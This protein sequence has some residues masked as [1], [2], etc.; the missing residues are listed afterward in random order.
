[1]YT[2]EIGGHV[3]TGRRRRIYIIP[4]SI[5]EVA[6]DLQIAEVACGC[7]LPAKIACPETSRAEAMGL[8]S[9]YTTSTR[10]V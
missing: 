10:S 1:M 7:K 3:W 9:E 4:A 8:G 5:A 2:Y 6:C